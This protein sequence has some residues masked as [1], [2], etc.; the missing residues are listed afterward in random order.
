MDGNTDMKLT[1]D[2]LKVLIE[3][4]L[5]DT[6]TDEQCEIVGI[7][8]ALDWQLYCKLVEPR[9]SLDFFK[10]GCEEE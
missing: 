9:C 3:D 7:D 6:L 2:E 4:G 8:I 5:F 1:Q 10:Y